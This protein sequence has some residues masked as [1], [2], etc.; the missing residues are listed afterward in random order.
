MTI[1]FSVRCYNT[2]YSIAVIASAQGS[3]IKLDIINIV[4]VTGK[5]LGT[6]SKILNVSI[7]KR[8]HLSARTICGEPSV[9]R[10]LVQ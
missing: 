8:E 7:V 1:H 6:A 2:N 9:D 5:M 3:H 10:L 4:L